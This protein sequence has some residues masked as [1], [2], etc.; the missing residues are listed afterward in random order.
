MGRK[1]WTIKKKT[2]INQY[3][4]EICKTAELISYLKCLNYESNVWIYVLHF[5]I[6]EKYIDFLRNTLSSYYSWIIAGFKI[7]GKRVVIIRF[8]HP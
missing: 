6:I 5:K 3:L 1:V 4:S 7:L 8:R 2:H